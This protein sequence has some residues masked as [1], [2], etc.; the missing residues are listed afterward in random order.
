EYIERTHDPEDER[1]IIVT[2]TEKGR[3]LK[4]K[5]SCV[6]MQMIDGMEIG[7]IKAVVLM[8]TLRQLMD[9]FREEQEGEPASTGRKKTNNDRPFWCW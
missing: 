7:N 6:P 9:T 4:G 8:K 5:I 1:N 2:L 3:G